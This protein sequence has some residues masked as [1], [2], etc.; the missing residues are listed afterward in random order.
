MFGEIDCREGLT[1][2]VDKLKYDTLKAAMDVLLDI[3]VG[4]CSCTSPCMHMPPDENLLQV[5]ACTYVSLM[6]CP[7][8]TVNAVKQM[9]GYQRL[10]SQR[11]QSTADLHMHACMLKLQLVSCN[12][13]VRAGLNTHVKAL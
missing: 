12:S 10:S 7:N 6:A 1:M 8:L 2:A 9:T 13:H 4:A 11:T 3:Y 5:Q